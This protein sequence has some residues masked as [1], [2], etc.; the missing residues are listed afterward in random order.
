M[1][2]S[3]MVLLIGAATLSASTAQELNKLYEQRGFCS[4]QRDVSAR[5]KCFEQLAGNAISAL[6]AKAA[7]V[8]T[9]QAAPPANSE[10][11][12]LIKKAKMNVTE[13]FKDP[14]SVLY[15]NLFVSKNGSIE[16]LCGE[17]NGRNSYG[18]L[19]GFRRFYSTAAPLLNDIEKPRDNYAFEQMLPRMCG[20]KIADVE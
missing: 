14:S 19:V 2:R 3:L 1:K 18:A 11:A 5:A 15:R 10:Y 12:D 20:N 17:L 4:A 16:V 7:P 9:A 6:E 13:N 8:P